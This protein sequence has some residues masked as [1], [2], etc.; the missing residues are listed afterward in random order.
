MKDNNSAFNSTEYDEKIKCTLPYYE[1]FYKQI[2][3]V[4]GTYYKDKSL[5][6][7]DVGCGTGKMADIAFKGAAIEQFIFCDNSVEMIGQAKE[8]FDLPN[9]QFIVS[10]VQDINFQ[11]EFDVVTAVQVNHYLKADERI[12]AIKKCYDALKSDGLFISFENFQPNGNVSEKLYLKQWKNYQVSMGKSN[13]E[14]ERHI[15]RYKKDFF[16]ISISEH[17]EVMKQCGF[18]EVEILW[19][20]YMQVGILGIKE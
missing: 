8:R 18:C 20:S 5:N 13:E 10:D 19:L 3:D 9:T 1:E 4:V 7:L 11:N 6:W 15:G 2:I 12:Y 14:S 16:P 17:L